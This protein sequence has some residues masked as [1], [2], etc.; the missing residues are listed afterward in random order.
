MSYLRPAVANYFGF[1]PA[2]AG[3]THS[4]CHVYLV[5]SSEASA[6]FPG[7]VVVYTTSKQTV[8]QSAG[9][10]GEI[11]LMVG[12]AASKVA[13]NEGST[14][15]S[16]PNRLSTQTVL[17]YDDP[18][19]LFVGC[20]TTSGVLGTT[21]GVGKS[22]AVL[23]VSTATA[24]LNDVDRSRMAISAVTASSGS[25]VGYAFRLVGLH[26]IENGFSTEAVNTASS[27]S[28]VRKWIVQPAFGHVLHGVDRG[29]VTT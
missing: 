15:V 13:A 16:N 27:S 12:V 6:I 8:R 18:H 4:R 5:S 9:T 21:P 22:F 3:G 29:H 23:L 24:T 20:D 28:E 17:V 7:D 11:G 26:P 10:T 1:S 2:E 25:D 14:S 19:Q